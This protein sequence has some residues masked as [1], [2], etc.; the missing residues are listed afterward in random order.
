M[1]LIFWFYFILPPVQAD[2]WDD[3]SNN[4]ATDLAPI[5]SLFGEQITKQYLSESIHNIDYF[6][7]ALAPIGILTAVVSAIRVC[8]SPSLRAFIGRAQEGGGSA[9]A[10][11]CSS[12]SR[13]VCELYNNGG[14]AR[15]FGR[16]KILEIV[17]DPINQGFENGTAGIYTFRNYLQA[18]GAKEWD[19][20]GDGENQKSAPSPNLSLN[21]GIKR[22]SRAIFLAVAILGT[23][24]QLGVLIFASIATYIL[25]WDKEGKQPE[26]YACPL[27]ILGTVLLFCGI[28]L[29]AFLIGESTN[30]TVFKRKPTEESNRHVQSTIYW[31]Q[32]GGQVLGDQAFDPFAYSDREEPLQQY[33][34]SWKTKARDSELLVW[35]AVSTTVA[36]FTLQ[37]TG[38]RALHSA[39]S[40]AQ[41]GVILLMSAARAALRMQRLKAEDNYLAHFPDIVT[42]HEL[43]WLA[44]R[45]G[46]VHDSSMFVSPA[47][48]DAGNSTEYCLWDFC[49]VT[50][51]KERITE[52]APSSR[53]NEANIAGRILAYRTRLAEL[54]QADKTSP[55]TAISAEHFSIEMVEVRETARKINLAIKS[56]M[57]IIFSSGLGVKHGWNSAAD[58]CWSFDCEVNVVDKEKK[59]SPEKPPISQA[60]TFHLVRPGGNGPWQLQNELTLEGLLGLWVWSLKLDAEPEVK[61]S[62]SQATEI[63][64]RRIVST[65]RD[66]P[67]AKLQAWLQGTILNF[68]KHQVDQIPSQRGSPS[69]VWQKSPDSWLKRGF[70]GERENFRF[71]GW[72]TMTLSGSQDSTRITVWSAP[73]TSSLTA[74]CAQEIFGSFLK[75]ILGIV[76][77]FG[78]NRMGVG[79]RHL[80]LASELVHD[81]VSIFVQEGWALLEGEDKAL[82]VQNGINWLSKEKLG[83]GLQLEH[84]V[85]S[86][87][88][89]YT[90]VAKE[91]ESPSTNARDDTSS[92]ELG[93]DRTTALINLS[94]L[95]S[96]TLN[97]KKKGNALCQ[98]AKKG[99]SEI[100]LALLE[101]DAD[102]DFIDESSH[103]IPP[104]SYAAESG[105]ID[106]VKALLEG[107]ASPDLRDSQERTPISYAAG[108]GRLSVV[109]LLL[110]TPGVDPDIEDHNGETPL[111]WAA[112]NGHL[113]VIKLLVR[114]DGQAGFI[115]KRNNNGTTP[116]TRSVKMGWNHVVRMLLDTKEVDINAEDVSGRTVLW[117]AAS[118]NNEIATRWLLE[119]GRVDSNHRDDYGRTPLWIAAEDGSEGVVRLLLEEGKA[120]PNQD[121]FEGRTPLS[122]AKKNNHKE[123]ARVLSRYGA[124]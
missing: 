51:D 42:G 99:W 23:A 34:T 77:Y 3:F 83:L 102:P 82:F 103:D 21:I 81:L 38:L 84:D 30:E 118:S 43:D 73:T 96:E 20:K 2:G 22:K 119:T 5:L 49:G 36:G 27:I 66:V 57:D 97:P 15:V 117:H 35:T 76:D 68:A 92:M 116:L 28:F 75:S 69:T 111:W 80:P 9:E 25:R 90:H 29:C 45:L 33:V 91:F 10:E 105:D 71:F 95:F 59:Q 7:F 107:W 78:P 108:S 46:Q 37:F 13:D 110:G 114:L 11:L 94:L 31:V 86:I 87:I 26:S 98:A 52:K 100:V 63:R 47:T 65:E 74:L 64:T 44:I 55:T 18:G 121:D 85:G 19:F 89:R 106:T 1:L 101:L 70:N 39:V 93:S 124:H 8:G 17:Y 62:V 40:V 58:I 56:A 72:H 67:E 32:P 120:D 50:D 6:I 4:L 115:D 109:Q 61:D 79:V 48:D 88:D 41:L 14:I 60:L 113:D 112:E 12:T 122:L 54:S 16:P 104:L 24:L 123:I 53:P